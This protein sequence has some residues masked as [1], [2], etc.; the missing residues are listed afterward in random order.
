MALTEHRAEVLCLG[1]LYQISQDGRP[2]P[3]FLRMVAANSACKAARDFRHTMIDERAI[4]V[5]MVGNRE[6]WPGQSRAFDAG[7]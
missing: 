4:E 1:P 7:E 5:T 3:S 2:E 6:K